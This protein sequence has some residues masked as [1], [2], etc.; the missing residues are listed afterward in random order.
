LRRLVCVRKDIFAE[1][2]VKAFRASAWR[3]LNRKQQTVNSPTVSS[4]P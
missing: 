4:K 3:L 2:T 1:P